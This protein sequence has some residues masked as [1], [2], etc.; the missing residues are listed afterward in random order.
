M[1][2]FTIFSFWYTCESATN[3]FCAG[4]IFALEQRLFAKWS[5]EPSIDE[6]ISVLPRTSVSNSTVYKFCCEWGTMPW[7]GFSL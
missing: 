3:I 7:A 4:D 1:F 5:L 6:V 2:C